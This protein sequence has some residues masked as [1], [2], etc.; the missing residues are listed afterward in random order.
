MALTDPARL[1]DEQQLKQ[2]FPESISNDFFEALFGDPDE[3]A[4]DIHL[5]FDKQVQNELQ[6]HFELTARPDKC[7]RCSLTYGLPN[8]FVRHPIINLDGVAQKIDN[9]LDSAGTVDHWEL[10]KTAEINSDLHFIPFT[11]Y[12]KA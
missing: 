3:G 10:G 12:L 5:I 9:I 8:V 1:F 11:I 6:F 2:I 4:Y 7:L